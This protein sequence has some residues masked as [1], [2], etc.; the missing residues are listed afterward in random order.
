MD[1]KDDRISSKELSLSFNISKWKEWRDDKK[2]PFCN[3]YVMMP[4]DDQE[5]IFLYY[6]IEDILPTHLK[7]GECSIDTKVKN[8]VIIIENSD[9][10]EKSLEV[11]IE[12]I[13][14]LINLYE[15]SDNTFITILSCSLNFSLEE[16]YVDILTE[17]FGRK[18]KYN[19][20]ICR[21]KRIRLTNSNAEEDIKA[22][23]DDYLSVL[24]NFDKWDRRHVKALTNKKKKGQIELLEVITKFYC[25]DKYVIKL[26]IKKK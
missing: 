20:E 11:M 13:S 26:H 10:D 4:E 17:K 18:I 24:D 22:A 15:I 1:F 2:R 5:T 19:P 16:E 7:I 25:S 21:N 9:N 23:I 8:E 6:S 14:I 3:L 12:K